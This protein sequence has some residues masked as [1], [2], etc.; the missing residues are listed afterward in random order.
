MT[1]TCL[2]VLKVNCSRLRKSLSIES[3]ACLEVWPLGHDESVLLNVVAQALPCKF[4]CA[5]SPSLLFGDA[6]DGC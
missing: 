5:G 1:K 2:K 4:L 3:F 6:D